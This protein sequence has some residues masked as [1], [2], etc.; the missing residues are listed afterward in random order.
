M[1]REREGSDLFYLDDCSSPV[2]A[3]EAA[4]AALEE[5]I[6]KKRLPMQEF[7]SAVG[8]V[9]YELSSQLDN[10][11]E[12]VLDRYANDQPVEL[13]FSLFRELAK[14]EPKEVTECIRKKWI[15]FFNVKE[16]FG[17]LTC[18]EDKVDDYEEEL[19]EAGFTVKRVSFTE[20][21]QHGFEDGATFEERRE[22]VSELLQ[23]GSGVFSPVC[24][25]P[26]WNLGTRHV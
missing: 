11:T 20:L 12:E 24:W 10:M 14:V 3:L 18:P 4:R 9:C 21:L 19:R 6:S 7:R 5:E 15:P 17:V 16:L 23:K 26:L 1:A 8:P 22:V 2:E 13:S 25:K